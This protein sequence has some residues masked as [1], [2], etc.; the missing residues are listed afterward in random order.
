MYFP[1]AARVAVFLADQ[2]Y[3]K[4]VLE[5]ADRLLRVIAGPV[6]DDDHLETRR[7]RRHQPSNADQE[8]LKAASPISRIDTN[9]EKRL[10][11]RASGLHRICRRQTGFLSTGVRQW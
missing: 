2:A 5:G 4:T 3:R 9:A 11:T 10:L 1:V 8:T 7:I 6:V